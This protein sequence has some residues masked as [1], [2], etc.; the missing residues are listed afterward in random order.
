MFATKTR[1]LGSDTRHMEML[2]NF[3]YGIHNGLALL[4]FLRIHA[5][6]A[7]NVVVERWYNRT[8]TGWV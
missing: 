1:N 2:L 7:Y 8:G 5:R 3:L 6:M 4:I